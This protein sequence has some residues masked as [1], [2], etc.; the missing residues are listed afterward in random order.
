MSDSLYD[1]LGGSEGIT[2]IAGDVVDNH[3]KN[4][5]VA[6]RFA[7][8]DL[9][10]LKKLAADFFIT[11]SGGPQVYEGKDMLA[12]HKHMNINDAEF[13][14]V[15][16]DVMNALESNDIGQR[17]REE[18]LFILYSLRPQIVHV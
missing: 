9:D 1:R 18:V 10:K 8:T 5:V 14:G 16:D 17:E 15:V 12:A 4:P 11:G 13:M 6:P 7:G 2:R 3:T